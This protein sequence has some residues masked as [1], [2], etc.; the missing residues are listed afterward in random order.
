MW[1]RSIA[2][3][4]KTICAG[5]HLAEQCVCA[6]ALSAMVHTLQIFCEIIT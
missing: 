2:L 6:M 4:R 1:R 5:T 3:H